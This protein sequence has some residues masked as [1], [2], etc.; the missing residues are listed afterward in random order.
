MMHSRLAR[1]VV[2]G[3][4]IV[5]LLL[6]QTAAVVHACVV[7]SAATQASA[8]EVETP[9]HAQNADHST[10]VKGCQDRCPSR[11]ASFETAKINIPAVDS[12]ALPVLTVAQPDTATTVTTPYE[13]IRACAAPPPLRLV[14]CRLLI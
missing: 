6:C 11:D 14:Y 8:V 10:P 4:F 3:V 12:L 1:R 5:M 7:P 2:T 13:Q 9:C